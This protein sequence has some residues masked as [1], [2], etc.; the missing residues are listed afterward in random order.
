MLENRPEEM[1]HFIEN[2][3]NNM[4]GEE[5]SH[6]ISSPIEQVENTKDILNT[7]CR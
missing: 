5:T 2:Y 3:L 6:V 7:P 1:T 4:W